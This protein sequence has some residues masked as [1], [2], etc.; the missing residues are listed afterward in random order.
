M[1]LEKS[2][3]A[4]RSHAFVITLLCLSALVHSVLIT[5]VVA[6]K[7]DAS[8][9]VLVRP[10]ENVRLGGAETPKNILDFPLGFNLP[11]EAPVRTFTEVIKSRTVVEQIVRKLGLDRP[12]PRPEPRSL[13]E[14]WDWLKDE[15][16]EFLGK[17]WDIVQ[18]GRTMPAD[19]F[20]RAVRELQK[21][22]SVTTTKNSYVFRISCL[23]KTPN[24]A[25]DIANEAAAVL[26]DSLTLLIQGEA[27]GSRE[28]LDHRLQGADRELADARQALR[29]FKEQNK[30]ILFTEEA[31]ER[32]K[33]ISDLEAS[34]EKI[35]AEL[36]SL[37]KTLTPLHPEVV[38]ALAKRDRL[39]ASLAQRRNKLK[40]LP[41]QESRLAALRLQVKVAEA[42]YEFIK[43]EYDEARLREVKTVTD[44][45]VVSPAA[46]PKS[47][48]KPIKIYYAG[49]ALLMAL[50]VGIGFALVR[51][52]TVE[53]LL[54]TIDEVEGSLALPVLA[55]IPEM[56]SAAKVLKA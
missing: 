11:Y 38:K 40:E 56:E 3:R 1:E 26:V 21:S 9:L 28:F 4:I 54:T 44:I 8:V 12:K 41:D 45:R 17:A 6:E 36:S 25:G 39:L 13:K 5:Y 10:A 22:I 43:K 20:E 7:Y 35:E 47:P 46:P 30:S 49:T 34:L 15:S 52:S 27:K 32:I 51:E 2:F 29:D 42:T 18:Y 16:S 19:P 14:I 50:M 53:P 23:W 37:T 24:L 48:A 33:I 31:N 55:T